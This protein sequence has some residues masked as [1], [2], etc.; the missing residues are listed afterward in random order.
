MIGSI[1][2]SA[3]RT[4]AHADA[5]DEMAYLIFTANG[6]EFD[7][8]ELEGPVVLGRAPDCDI[9]VPDIMLSRHHCR[10]EP[11]VHDDCE[12][13]RIIDLHSKNGVHLRG[14]PI[15]G[16]HDLHDGE[17]LRLGRTRITFRAGEFV[18]PAPHV[19]RRGVIRPADPAEAL[20]GTV[21]GMVLC[22]PEE[23]QKQEQFPYP[24]PRPADPHAYTDEGVYGLIDQIVSSSWD[25]IMAQNARPV[26]MQRAMPAPQA[27]DAN[28]GIIRPRPRVSFCLQA[29]HREQQPSAPAVVPAGPQTRARAATARRTSVSR[30]RR[31]RH[32]WVLVAGGIAGTAAFIVLWVTL[33]LS[34]P[35]PQAGASSP[36]PASPPPPPSPS[37]PPATPSVAQPSVQPVEWDVVA[38]SV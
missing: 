30:N 1:R 12:G 2:S 37:Q 21:T 28:R 3:D 25:S 29:E 20:A 7:R 8:R 32:P 18:P 24:K 15:K 4:R 11:A 35:N 13:W 22:D 31:R 6:E 9:S 14:R 16:P 10:L 33:I 27:T 23:V 34:V 26:Q 36:S 19:R 5:A 38:E 17:E